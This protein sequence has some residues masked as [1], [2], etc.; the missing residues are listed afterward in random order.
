MKFKLYYCHVIEQ[1]LRAAEEAR[2]AELKAEKERARKEALLLKQLKETRQRRAE[3][4]SR[5]I[6]GMIYLLPYFSKT[7]H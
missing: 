7:F 6:E 5:A 4:R 2:K 1:E 3:E